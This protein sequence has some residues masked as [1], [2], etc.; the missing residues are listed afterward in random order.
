M[1]RR[2]IPRSEVLFL[3]WLTA[4]LWTSGCVSPTDDD[5]GEGS[6]PGVQPGRV[7]LCADDDWHRVLEAQPLLFDGEGGFEALLVIHVDA[8]GDVDLDAA[9]AVLRRFFPEALRLVDPLPE[10]VVEAVGEA[11]ALQPEVV[12]LADLWSPRRPVLYTPDDY[13]LTLAAAAHAGHLGYALAIAGGELEAAGLLEGA[14]VIPV[15]AVDCPENAT[16]PRTIDDLETLRAE[17]A[18]ILDGEAVIL[19]HPDDLDQPVDAVLTTD[20]GARIDGLYGATSLVS[21]YL[22][23]ARGALLLGVGGTTGEAVDAGLETL[24]A[25]LAPEAS[26]LTIMGSP[27][28][29]PIDVEVNGD[30][31]FQLDTTVYGSWSRGAV[32]QG[33]GLWGNDTLPDLYT[34]RILGLTV[35][36][37]SAHVVN[38][39]F[40][41]RMST[42]WRGRAYIDD[43]GGTDHIGIAWRL[44]DLYHASGWTLAF[45]QESD[46]VPS[47]L[48]QV[49]T[50]HYH[51]HGNQ[52]QAGFLTTDLLQDEVEDLFPA[53]VFLSACLTCRWDE[54]APIY[55]P[56]PE[57]LLCA[58]L[59]R[60]GALSVV[61]AV[62]YGN[63]ENKIHWFTNLWNHEQPAG[64]AFVEMR[65]E[66]WSTWYHDFMNPYVMLGDPLARP[67]FAELDAVGFLPATTVTETEA[68]TPTRSL[69]LTFS[70]PLDLTAFELL[71][72][73]AMPSFHDTTTGLVGLPAVF[74]RLTGFLPEGA[75]PASLAVTYRIEPDWTLTGLYGS[76]TASDR[77]GS[78]FDYRASE[79]TATRVT[80]CRGGACD[81]ATADQA[82]GIRFP[83]AVLIH[84]PE[85]EGTGW[86]LT[87]LKPEIDPASTA[88]DDLLADPLRSVEV[89][90]SLTVQ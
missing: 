66:V 27:K 52:T 63:D 22:A 89:D 25:G 42:D 14:E 78:L 26:S 37:V 19:V 88:A 21:P 64:R 41:D 56:G 87:Y 15:G 17:T 13:E 80:V 81:E 70:H 29:I 36:D 55:E 20:L 6:D 34:G 85:P 82:A 58:W 45:N 33:Q 50:I 83:P 51:G 79:C 39:L 9:L 2:A 59:I 86:V 38:S 67:A 71:D 11:A 84:D 23:A 65:Q 68:G 69:T 1:N 54:D 57:D 4:V 44:A 12:D 24:L 53:T 30:Y 5:T 48:E 7:T 8:D 28:A 46:L 47:D 72:A 32:P 49:T 90:L 77:S 73:P 35:T 40:S 10:G 76:C 43:D 62:G 16:C 74:G 18:S 3:L 31:R 61:T 75:V 60:R